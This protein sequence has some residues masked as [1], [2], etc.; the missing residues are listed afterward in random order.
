[1]SG[2]FGDNGINCRDVLGYKSGFVIAVSVRTALDRIRAGKVVEP[3][4]LLPI[5]ERIEQAI[6]TATP[7]SKV[8][9]ERRTAYLEE[10]EELGECP[11]PGC[12][13]EGWDR[14]SELSCDS[15]HCPSKVS[16]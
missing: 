1:M 10:L 6:D 12:D 2:D 16:T 14:L 7:L 8:L 15:E 13:G 9:E 3:S 4:E 5:L 11:N